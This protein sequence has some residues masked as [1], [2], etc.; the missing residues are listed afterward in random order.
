[1]ADYLFRDHH[2]QTLSGARLCDIFEL[3]SVPIEICCTVVS[4]ATVGAQTRYVGQAVNVGRARKISVKYPSPRISRKRVNVLRVFAYI[5]AA[6]NGSY[7]E[8]TQ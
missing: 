1:M 3:T 5:K 4:R 8:E 6:Q 7:M 2:R